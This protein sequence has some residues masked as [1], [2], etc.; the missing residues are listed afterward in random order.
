M[1][2]LPLID[3][4]VV[5]FVATTTTMARREFLIAKGL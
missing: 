3:Q 5:S 4:D 2:K 1:L